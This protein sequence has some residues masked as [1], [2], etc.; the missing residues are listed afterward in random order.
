V[1]IRGQRHR[2]G[3]ADVAGLAGVSVSTASKILNNVPVSARPETRQRVLDAAA[4]LNY[5]PNLTARALVKG[6]SRALALLVPELTNPVYSEMIRGAFAEARALGYTVMVAEDGEEHGE[7]DA[8]FSDLV[9]AG[10]VDG[11]LIGSARPDHPFIGDLAKRGLPHVFINRPVAGSG[12]NVTMDAAAVSELAV[13]HLVE[14]G[15]EAIAHASGPPNLETSSTRATAF[16]AEARRRGVRSAP[17]HHAPAFDEASG[18]SAARALLEQ[19]GDLT[20]IYSTSLSQAIGV[21]HVIHERGLRIPD[22]ISVVAHDDLPMADFLWPA[23][24]TIA[25]PMAELGRTSVRA[26]VEQIC[27]AQPRDIAIPIRPRLV[28]RGSS[29]PRR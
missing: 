19:H 25:M 29:A 2:A 13:Q 21:M 1:A 18:A 14:L 24:D 22:D 9:A 3:L 5:Q 8:S 6:S 27:G 28:L 20:A 11:L 4:Q 16:V 10:H 23:L 15:H 12:R 7:G 17:V 26:L